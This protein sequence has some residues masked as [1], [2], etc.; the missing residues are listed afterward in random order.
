M[1]SWLFLL[2]YALY[3]SN[4]SNVFIFYPSAGFQGHY[5]CHAWCICHYKFLYIFLGIWQC[6]LYRVV[7]PRS[8][9]PMH[10]LGQSADFQVVTPVLSYFSSLGILGFIRIR[11]LLLV[12]MKALCLS[13][14]VVL[15]HLLIVREYSTHINEFDDDTIVPKQRKPCYNITQYCWREGAYTLILSIRLFRG[16][17]TMNFKLHLG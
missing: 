2:L 4:Q 15:R 9:C 11:S 8:V 3:I 17:K 1:D 16:S 14:W 7:Y 10:V 13:S 6:Y 12:L 5:W